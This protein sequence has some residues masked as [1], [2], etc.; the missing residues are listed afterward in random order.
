M[1]SAAV[2]GALAFAG[3]PSAAAVPTDASESLGKFLG[4]D[5]VL[6]NVDLDSIA[7]VE[8]ADAAYPSG[9]SPDTNPLAADVLNTLDVDLTDTLQL[10]GPGGI[11]ELGAVN[12]YAGADEDGSTSASGAV[13][14]QGAISLGGSEQ[15]PADATVSLTPLVPEALRDSTVSQ[16]DLS[17]GALSATAQAEPGSDPTGD[18]QIAGA[19][20]DL[21]SPLVGNV[22]TQLQNAITPVQSSLDGLEG[23]L[24][25]A[26]DG[27]INVNLAVARSTGAVDVAVPDL[28]QAL[29]TGFVGDG[30]V[31]VNLETGEVRVDLEQLLADDPDLPD[32]DELPANYEILNGDVVA[33]ISD[34]VTSTITS[35]VQD[36]ADGVHAA[37]EATAV[38]VDIDFQVFSVLTWTDVLSLDLD[39]SLAEIDAGTATADIDVLGSTALVNTLLGA[40]G[41]GSTQALA[42]AVV[43]ALLAPVGAV[44]T[45]LD[46]MESTLDGITGPLATEVVGPVLDVLTGVVSL[47]GNVQEQPGD[48][49]DHDPSGATSF[50]ERALSVR[51]LSLGTGDDLATVNLASATVRAVAAPTIA[52]DPATVQADA[53]TTIT[54]AG[55][56]PETPLTVRL[57]DATT[58]DPVG[59]P[60]S[61]TSDGDGAFSVPLPVGADT[62]PADYTVTATGDPSG[63]VPSAPLTVTAAPSIAADPGTVP[64]GGSTTI[65]GESFT[66]AGDVTVQLVDENGDAVGD[67]VAT[68]ADD[69]GA[70]E[71]ALPTGA[72]TAPGAYT[73]VATDA[74]TG[75]TAEADLA[76]TAAPAITLDP[77][78]VTPGGTTTVTG[79]GFTPGSEVSVQLTDESGEP[80]GD[81]I[82]TTA[83]DAGAIGVPF[84]VP[85]DAATGDYSVAA[86]DVTGAT[87]TADLTVIDPAVTTDP[88]T[89]PAG[90]TTTVTGSGFTPGGEVTVQLTGP[91]GTPVGE[92]VTTT[93][94]EAGAIEVALPTAP[95]TAPGTYAVVAT[96]VSGLTAEVPLE[97]T[98]TPTI[99]VDPGTVP[100]GGTTTVTGDG[101][102]PGG[103]VTLQ[104]TDADGDPVGDPVTTTA[105]DDGAIEVDVPVPADTTPGDLA[106]VATDP[107]GATAEAPLE[108]TEAPTI[109]ADPGTVPA[110]GTTTVTG[111]GFTPGGEVTLQLTDAAGDPV[112]SPVT[113]AAGP[114]GEVSTPLTVPSGTPSGPTTVVATDATGATADAPLA[115]TGPPSVAVDPG[116]VPAGGTTTVTGGGFTP[117]EDVT[118]QLTDEDGEPVGDAVT[119]TATDAGTIEVELTVPAD[120]APGDHTVVATDSSGAT[121]DAPLTVTAAPTVAVDPGTVPAGGTTTVTGAGFTPGEDVTVQLTDD[122]GN[123]VG[124]PV[125][126]TADDSGA[127]EV[128]LPVPAGTTP[129]G[130]TVVASDVTGA[131]AEAPLAVTAAPTIAADP[132]TV[133]AGGTTTVTGEG[134]TPGEDVTVQLTDADGEPVGDPV[135]TTATDAGAIEAVVPT[136]AGTPLGDHTV[137]A[138]DVS[139]A[140]AEAPLVVTSAPTIAV[141]P[142]TVPAGGSTTVTGDG[143]TPGEDITVQLTDADGD[144]VGEPVTTTAG[145][146]G[147]ISVDLPVPADTTPGDLTVVATDSSGAAAE[148]P[149]EVTAAPTIVVDPGTVPAGGTTTVTGEG[150]TPDEDVTVQLMD[151]DGDPV[152]SPVTTT[153][154]DDGTISVGLPVPADTTP[155][156]FT[157]VASDV[158]GAAAEAPLTVTPAP[159]L[160]ADPGT[161]PAGGATTVTGTG[162]TPGS[163]VA[164]QLT[165][166][167]GEPLGSPTTVTAGDDGGFEVDIPVPADA[168]PGDHSVVAQD[169][170]GATAQAPLEITTAPTITVEPGTVPA[171]GTTTVTGDGFTPGADVV[172]QLTDDAGNPVGDP[173]S[174]TAGDD[175]TI[176]VDLPVPADTTPGDLTVVAI[177]SSGATAEAQLEVTA[178]PTIVVAP[179]TVP[180]GGTTTVTGEG[181]TPGED[182]TVQLTDADGDAVGDPVTTTADDDG[183]ISVDLPVPADTAPGDLTV[184][185]TDSSGAAAE[186]PLEVTAAPTIA[187]DPGTITAG[188]ATTVSGD[189][190]TP[191]GEVSVQLTDADGDPVGSPVTT[192]ADDDG[193]I[194]VDL[195]VPA[196]TAPGDLT[197]V[198]TDS[199]GAAAEAP[200]V[201]TAP[202]RPTL[203]ADP[204]SVPAGGTTTVSGGG[205]VPG[206]AV[207]VQLED[208]AGAPVGD[209]IDV[210]VGPD[211]TFTVV[212]PVPDDAT[213][214]NHT[215][216]AT[217]SDGGTVEADLIVTVGAPQE[218]I[219]DVDP[220]SAAPGDTVTVT[221][222]GFGGGTVSVQLVGPDGEPVGDPVEC[223]PGDDGSGTVELPVPDD[224]EPGD[225]TVVG[226][227][228]DGTTAEAPL[229]VT[230]PG[231]APG[232]R[233]LRAWFSE[234]VV[235]RGDVQTFQASGFDPGEQ[236]RAVVASEPVNLPVT[237][238]DADG[239]ATWTFDVPADF[240]LGIHTGTATSVEAGDSAAATFRVVLTDA[241][242]DPESGGAPGAPDAGPT[243][244]GAG[245]LPRTGPGDLLALSLL[246]LLLLT[247]GAAT[248]A[249]TRRRATPKG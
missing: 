122:A 104:L 127:V 4:G 162:F 123:P 132:G 99:V 145:D 186:A 86:T 54:G 81:P 72:G 176:E 241:G 66:P 134:F 98:E 61:V 209:A 51:L 194:S 247:A 41:L 97:V 101:F 24:T 11:V 59:D 63:V 96:D 80:V 85:A 181:F 184:V 136:T 129:G 210:V 21:T 144:P 157:V 214:G 13:T 62:A 28:T 171:G 199:S 117:G 50:T 58:G 149:L 232:E 112:G 159:A 198:A 87:A 139:G 170:T 212:L 160:V 39:A 90:G 205:F 46:T 43:N 204:G 26:L 82:T 74:G 192:T 196:D 225:H 100:A 245:T 103:E 95:G 84:V 20:L 79:T 55:F 164:V 83:T 152:G 115:V 141:D 216:V 7:E 215:V 37:V 106:V 29:P 65:T 36:V 53:R 124:D 111:D 116:T 167:D 22:Y 3:A 71:V 94:T 191:G 153:A 135:T 238:A 31:Q 119:T 239:V 177:D 14:D 207:T 110:G 203:T 32:L 235:G 15:F 30:A 175:G 10:F 165:D 133:P 67:P 220:G 243:T 168:E 150:F 57:T 178:A 102:T 35:V 42:S 202:E 230:D 240:E 6:G 38:S 142:G 64:A 224:A 93:A 70:V 222:D 195:P 179:G 108:V 242:L 228:P 249:T 19:T 189:G 68:T 25:T 47:T 137:V 156:D 173:V 221:C 234:D 18:Y 78:T 154:G 183:A 34:A 44:F 131:T 226:T 109:V 217:T 227:G 163:D 143:F 92:P 185:A 200:L 213:P 155:G 201:V 120:A 130:Y 148:A 69:A 248:V 140:T 182:V 75:A 52:A 211:G 180:A 107:S 126:T 218:P 17:L 231:T 118:V 12:Q 56:A 146:D 147:A 16:L 158:T 197:V 223:V 187:A 27:L 190:F 206:D 76:V 5:V 73:V 48:L 91:G 172:V 193:A 236:V 89:V 166:P 77:T 229:T 60:V 219:I 8:G 188:D 45:L 23:T 1:T 246:A 208:A 174:A 161:V 244:P 169:V 138:T 33:A 2:L 88:G 9:T 113:V 40:L 125:T 237:V 114:G 151:A 128:D 233:E 105:G 49:P 121:A